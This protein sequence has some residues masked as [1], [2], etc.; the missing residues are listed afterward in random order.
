VGIVGNQAKA[1]VGLV[2]EDLEFRDEIANAG[3]ESLRR[4]DDCDAAVVVPLNGS[5][6]FKFRQQHFADAG[7]YAGRVGERLGGRDA[8]LPR[9]GSEGGLKPLQMPH[10]VGLID[11]HKRRTR[12]FEQGSGRGR[13]ERLG[14]C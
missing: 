6:L 9:P 4:L 7:R 2:A 8:F 10:A 11:A 5:R 13:L 1:T 12:A 3:L 14:G